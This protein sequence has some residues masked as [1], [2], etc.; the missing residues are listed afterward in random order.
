MKIVN[1]DEI[2]QH[3]GITESDL[4]N[5]YG[6]SKAQYDDYIAHYGI[7][8][9]LWGFA[10]GIR[11]AGKRIAGEASY[12]LQSYGRS[13]LEKANIRN[14]MNQNTK[15]QERLNKINSSI[16]TGSVD[17]IP[18]L[19]ANAEKVSLQNSISGYKKQRNQRIKQTL[20]MPINALSSVASKGK[21]LLSN[22]LGISLKSRTIKA[23]NASSSGPNYNPKSA[24]TSYIYSRNKNK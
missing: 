8:G 14:A 4:M 3:C 12:Q 23:A 10:N 22:L 5:Y 9:M 7:K 20:S 16:K 11:Q 21:S 2:L 15:N 18:A 1:N 24:A 6:L 19:L 17:G 13:N